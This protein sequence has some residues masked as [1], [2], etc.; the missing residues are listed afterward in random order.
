MSNRFNQTWTKDDLRIDLLDATTFS[1]VSHG[2][3]NSP[4]TRW[5]S[6]ERPTGVEN[7]PPPPDSTAAQWRFF[8]HFANA[9]YYSVESARREGTQVLPGA[10]PSTLPPYNFGNP[11]CTITYLGACFTGS[12]PTILQKYAWPLG[13]RYAPS[14]PDGDDDNE[15]VVAYLASPQHP[16]ISEGEKA[17]WMQMMQGE[18]VANS[19]EG[20][21]GA[22][23]NGITPELPYTEINAGSITYFGDGK[24]KA[25]G[26]YGG[27]GTY[28][29]RKVQ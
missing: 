8:A 22:Y 19:L 2:N 27:Q 13:T 17:F 10:D 25:K 23:N 12:D 7:G 14:P 16:G 24:A 1:L 5:A 21:I 28:W 11:P 20:I 29:W 9:D 6:N 18:T 15:A 4:G 3:T 26:V